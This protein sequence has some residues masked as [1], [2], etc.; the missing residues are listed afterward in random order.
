MTHSS[1][2]TIVFVA[3]DVGPARYLLALRQY[4][5]KR[6]L[7]CGSSLTNPVFESEGCTLAD[8]DYALTMA[9]V[10]VTGTCLGDG[11]DKLATRM[12]RNSGLTVISIVEHWSWFQE[13]FRGFSE[14]HMPD[15]LLVNDVIALESAIKA[16]LA[17]SSLR[18]VGNPVLE[19]LARANKKKGVSTRRSIAG[20]RTIVFV[21]ESLADDKQSGRLP[22]ITVTEYDV[23]NAILVGRRAIDKVMV[24]LHPTEN[25]SKF[26]YL[27]DEIEIL[28]HTSI[29]EI[30]EVAD[31]VV[32]LGSILLLELAA[33]GCSVISVD[34]I[35]DVSFIGDRTGAT[36]SASSMEELRRLIDSPPIPDVA[37]AS[38]FEGSGSRIAELI[39]IVA[40]K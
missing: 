28:A 33:L 14:I 6:L 35:S 20:H 18:V 13:R 24:K 9:D 27:G 31:V 34:H 7:W 10:V 3:G 15:M 19:N 23:L 4:L 17:P 32:G 2:G 40:S 8:L 16:G 1:M 38:S 26:D 25:P 37:F 5:T 22:N 12:A 36:H 21:S 11:I 30:A 39:S 29:E